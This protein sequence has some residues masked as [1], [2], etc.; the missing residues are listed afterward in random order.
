MIFKPPNHIIDILETEGALC[1]VGTGRSGKTT[2][3]HLLA[4]YSTKPVIALAYPQSA[5]DQCPDDWSSVSPED[6]F[7]LKDC[8]LLVDDAALFAS[9][10]NFASSWS[11]RWIQFQTIISH[12]SITLIFVIQS[13]N[14]L[15]IGTLRSQRMAV[16]Y[17]YSDETN[18]M[19]ER[20]EF[21][22]VAMTTRQVISR[23]RKTK[24][25]LHPKSWVYDLTLGKAW[26]HPL[27]DHWT[28]S[29]S[30]PYRDYIVEEYK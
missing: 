19:Y 27:P 22:R 30:V 28:P 25:H 1:C 17:K 6:V 26:S 9:S 18:V 8:V 3:A 5:I 7:S 21:K 16:L 13:T 15:D 4:N 23:L 20:D 24:P 11:K 29:L 12:K 14:L 10:R 2:M